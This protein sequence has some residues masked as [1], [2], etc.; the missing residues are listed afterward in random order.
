MTDIHQSPES[1]IEDDRPL[2][3]FA[4]V[5]YGDI[6]YW[7][8]I[9]ATVIVLIGSIMT[10]VAPESFIDPAYLLSAIWEGKTVDEIWLGA[11][12]ATPD[13]HWYLSHLESGNGITTAGIALGVFSVTP[14]ILG[15]A[16]VL[17]RKKQK[18]FGSLAVIS[19]LITIA[20]MLA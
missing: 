15:A 17:F 11:T 18:L 19:A 13:G 8:T 10:F 14:A 3:P 16:F 1:N 7:G 12:G 5:V 6:I 2:V 20:A 9:A 4:G